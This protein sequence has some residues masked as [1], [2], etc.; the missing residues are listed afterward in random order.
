MCEADFI[1]MYLRRITCTR[2]C[3]G[4]DPMS[5]LRKNAFIFGWFVT[6][7]LSA[8]LPSSNSKCF[9]YFMCTVS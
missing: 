6:G 7:E 3:C 9:A 5:F 1:E 2:K 4:S 8:T